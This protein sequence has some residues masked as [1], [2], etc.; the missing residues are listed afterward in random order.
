[1]RL[2]RSGRRTCLTT[3]SSG[4]HAREILPGAGQRTPWRAAARGGAVNG[5]GVC[6]R[7]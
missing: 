2:S 3:P 6:G 1:L 4:E 5:E 7:A